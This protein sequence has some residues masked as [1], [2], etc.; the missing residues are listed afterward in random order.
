[1]FTEPP[2]IAECAS[3]SGLPRF[4]SSKELDELLNPKLLEL[5]EIFPSDSLLLV[6]ELEDEDEDIDDELILLLYKRLF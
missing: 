1:L 5:L 6:S 3:K 2:F 4:H